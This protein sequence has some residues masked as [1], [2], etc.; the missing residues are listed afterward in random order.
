M[1]YIGEISALATAVMWTGSSLAFAAATTRIGSVYVNVTRLFFAV[2]LLLGTILLAGIPFEVSL[3]QIWFLVLSGLVGFVF[4]DTF[5]FKS[6]EYNSAR[7]AALIMSAVP[8]ITAIFAYMFLRETLAPAG[9]AGMAITLAGIT[10][11]VAERKE[12]SSH[13]VPI[14]MIGVFY[15]FLAAIGQAG[16]LILAKNAFALGPINGFLATLIRASSAVIIL[17]LMNY[18]AGRY[19]KPI[20]V[21]SKD[22]KALSFTV[23]G[24][25]FG[26]F[27]GVTFSLISISLTK[28][29]IAATIMALVPILMLPTVRIF[30]HEHLSWRAIVG[31]CVAVVGVGVLFLR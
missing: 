31:A 3:R 2:G 11:V 9:I 26:P 24:S 28:V 20:E 27:L 30:F 23:L 10:L 13:P 25:V 21:Y 8:A 16:G 1:S 22:R 5:L 15:A 18:A 6:Y 4:G 29:A 14:S 19:T 12:L 17:A 7:I